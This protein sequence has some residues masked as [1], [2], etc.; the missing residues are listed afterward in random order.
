[1]GQM[2]FP[3]LSFIPPITL[4]LLM[5]AQYDDVSNV[6]SRA[7]VPEQEAALAVSSLCVP[8]TTLARN[9]GCM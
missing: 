8:Q 3:S 7:A 5:D 9:I 1:M 4:Q 2:M 6:M